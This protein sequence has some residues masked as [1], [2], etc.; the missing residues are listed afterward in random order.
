MA[1]QGM[2]WLLDDTDSSDSETPRQ[3][4]KN[5]SKLMKQMA[6]SDSDEESTL[7]GDGPAH[8]VLEQEALSSSSSLRG[9]IA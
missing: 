4:A 7:D 2:E 8:D 3:Q 1:V 9:S 6:I 5:R